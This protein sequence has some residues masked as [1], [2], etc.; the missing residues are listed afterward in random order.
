M[1]GTKSIEGIVMLAAKDIFKTI[2][3]RKYGDDFNVFVSFYEIYCGQLFD[4]I[5][6]RKRLNALENAKKA[7]CI[8]GLEEKQVFSHKDIIDVSSTYN[9]PYGL[10]YNE[11][12]TIIT[13]LKYFVTC[14]PWCSSHIID[15]FG[16]V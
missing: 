1:T 12:N 7:I 5:N 14:G 15:V 6:K 2:A 3:S 4:L 9:T 10:D 13:N 8:V 11:I 16:L